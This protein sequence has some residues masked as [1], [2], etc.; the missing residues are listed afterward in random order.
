MAAWYWLLVVAV[1]VWYLSFTAGMA[2]ARA[3]LPW[4][5]AEKRPKG[6]A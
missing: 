4:F 1:V 6:D 2:W 3:G 5:G